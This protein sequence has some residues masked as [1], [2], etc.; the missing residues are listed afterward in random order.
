MASSLYCLES[1]SLRRT[2]QPG[3]ATEGSAMAIQSIDVRPQAV[4]EDDAIVIDH[5]VVTSPEAVQTARAFAER[6]QHVDVGEHIEMLIDIGG[7]AVS[8]G[9]STVDVDEIKRSLDR[10][11]TN[12]AASAKTSV[13]CNAR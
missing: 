11:T 2:G 7:K 1:W 4:V 5:L 13:R 9:S 10:F 3:A 8:I 6:T 12:V